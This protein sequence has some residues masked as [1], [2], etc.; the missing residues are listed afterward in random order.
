MISK[1]RK[2]YLKNNRKRKI[3]IHSLRLMI[4]ALFFLIWE[5]LARLDIIDTFLLSSPSKVIETLIKLWNNNN[6][7]NHIFTTLKEI[8]ISFIIGN[9]IGFI[10]A[11]ILWFSEIIHKILEPYLTIINSLPKVALGPLIIILFGANIRSVI[12]MALLISTIISIMYIYTAFS[13]TDENRIKIIKSMGGNKFDIFYRLVV[14][15]NIKVIIDSFKINIS[16]CFVGVIMG[17]FLVSKNGIGYL[18]NYGSQIFNMN[19]VITGIIILIL[20]TI[21]LYS[22]ISLLEK[23]T[24]KDL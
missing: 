3:L 9:I 1:E 10:I 12:I 4:L 7:L 17:E 24:N 18:I 6:L 23:K 19:L 11:S 20:L 14:P 21:L 13:N 8:I 5:I 22:L 2:E 15:L 16:M